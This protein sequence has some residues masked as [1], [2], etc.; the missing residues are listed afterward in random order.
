M[1]CWWSPFWL[2][3]LPN[4]FISK[5]KTLRFRNFNDVLIS[6]ILEELLV[7]LGIFYWLLQWFWSTFLFSLPLFKFLRQDRAFTCESPFL[8]DST[9]SLSFEAS[10]SFLLCFL[11]LFLIPINLF[12]Q[13]CIVANR[14]PHMFDFIVLK[15]VYTL[16]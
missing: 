13:I 11:F 8:I 10:I 15:F 14:V 5:Y 2:L 6:C 16:I 3:F 9:I 1:I 4:V 7:S 12:V